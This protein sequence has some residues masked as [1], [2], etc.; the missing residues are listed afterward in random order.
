MTK[1]IEEK[2]MGRITK[3]RMKEPEEEIRKYN[4]ICNF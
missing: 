3:R 2:Y 4:M 1:E